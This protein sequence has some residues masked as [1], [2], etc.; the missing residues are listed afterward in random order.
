MIQQQ[1]KERRIKGKMDIVLCIDATGSMEPCIEEL[2]KNLRT[3]ID[4]LNVPYS[5]QQVKIDWRARVIYFRDLDVDPEALKEFDFVNSVD[6]LKKQIESI[7]AEGGGDEPESF[8][9]AIY[10]AIAKSKWR[11]DTLHAVVAFTDA[12]AKDKLH[13]STIEAGQDPTVGTVINAFTMDKYSRL[14]VYC[15]N[16]KIYNELEKIPRSS[17]NYIGSPGEEKV[18]EGL[19]NLDFS[20]LLQELGKT[21][22]VSASEV[23]KA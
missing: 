3:F 5:S 4:S 6:E 9:D 13:S 1:P 11:D 2:K 10:T 17:F 7:K 12:P 16:H 15:P 20:K 18:Y 8:L 21:L 22:V 14:F 19:R 23:I